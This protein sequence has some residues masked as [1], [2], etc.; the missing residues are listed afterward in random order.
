ME[1]LKYI[2]NYQFVFRKVIKE[3]KRKEVDR[4][5]LSAKNKNKALWN[6][7]NTET[8]NSQWLSNIIINTWGK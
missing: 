5:I 3:A 2:Q 4:L 7:I 1:S 6:I 8:G